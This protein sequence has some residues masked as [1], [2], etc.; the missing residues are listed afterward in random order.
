MLKLSQCLSKTLNLQK[1]L[2]VIRKIQPG[3]NF[4]I[5]EDKPLVSS[6]LNV[7]I[8]VVHGTDQI[9]K[10]FETKLPHTEHKDFPTSSVPSSIDLTP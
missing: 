1:V 7:S 8:D 4:S 9:I 5:K 6:W 2:F 10:H 3:D